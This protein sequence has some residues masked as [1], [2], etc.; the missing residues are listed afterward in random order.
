MAV[1]SSNF[2][3]TTWNLVAAQ[4]PL[5][6]FK[7]K[8]WD[9]MLQNFQRPGFNYPDYY[10]TQNFHGIAGGYLNP[11]AAL[12]YDLVSQWLLLP[13]EKWVRQSAIA[14]IQIK[15]T[16]ILDLGCGTGSSTM[17][18]KKT[19]PQADVIGLDLSPYMLVIAADKADR[20]GLNIHFLQGRAENTEFTDASFDL[21]S[22]SMVFHE[23]PISITKAIL[24]E[25]YRLLR[26]G[27]EL[28]ILD[29]NQQSLR[30]TSW[31]DQIIVEPYLNVYASGSLDAWMGAIGFEAVQ[32]NP[33]W[34]IYQV[35]R[36]IKS[37]I[38]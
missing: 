24:Q 29:G 4:D 7:G 34:W 36:G 38:S 33:T 37:S 16:R 3:S 30:R 31:V 9:T 2:L 1:N 23:T 35:S 13:H 6:W 19:F 17:L 25:G 12:S 15:P 8:D 28:I 32:T 18:L 22:I 27:G 5:G 21:V 26:S 10:V 11:R 14:A 20:Y